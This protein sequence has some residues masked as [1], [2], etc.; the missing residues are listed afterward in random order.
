MGLFSRKPPVTVKDVAF[1]A[2][3]ALPVTDVSKLQ[4][5]LQK[6]ADGIGWSDRAEPSPVIQAQLRHG[7]SFYGKTTA[8]VWVGK[9]VIGY[10]GTPAYARLKDSID[11]HDGLPA[12]VQLRKASVGYLADVCPA[13]FG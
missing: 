2:T 8:G 9:T 10:L 3:Q 11:A 13:A 6:V 5:S 7:T 1:D 12:A 4:G